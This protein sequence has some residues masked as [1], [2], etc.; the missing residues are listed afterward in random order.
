MGMDMLA[1]RDVGRGIADDLGELHHRFTA[2]NPARGDLV[3]AR[4]VAGAHDTLAWNGSAGG[5]GS[6]GDNDIV[7]IVQPDGTRRFD[8]E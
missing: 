2:G 6:G 5:Q 1:R 8:G 3:T 7:G 4:H